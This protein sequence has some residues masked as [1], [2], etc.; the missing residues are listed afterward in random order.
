VRV[1]HALGGHV[2]ASGVA[3]ATDLAWLKELRFDRA[4]GSACGPPMPASE[5]PAYVRT[6][7]ARG[8][9][10]DPLSI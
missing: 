7:R 6:T 1:G 4:Q 5:F 8:S 9:G 10:I 3:T 2:M